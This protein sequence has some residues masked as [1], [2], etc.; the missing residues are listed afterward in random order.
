MAASAPVLTIPDTDI[1][2]SAQKGTSAGGCGMSEISTSTTFTKAR[3]GTAVEITGASSG[4]A[5]A[6]RKTS[7]TR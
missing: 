2:V 7:R 3:R 1:T 6:A 4:L 5:S